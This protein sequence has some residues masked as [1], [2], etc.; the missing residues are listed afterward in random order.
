M[1]SQNKYYAPG[2]EELDY[3]DDTIISGLIAC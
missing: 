3:K 2:M 1:Q